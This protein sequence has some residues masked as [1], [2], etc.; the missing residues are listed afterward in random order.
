LQLSRKSLT[1]IPPEAP[2]NSDENMVQLRP[3]MR[4]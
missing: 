2:L 1:S 3:I 4:V